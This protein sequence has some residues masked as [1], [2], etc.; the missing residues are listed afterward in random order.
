MGSLKVGMISHKPLQN[1][2][3]LSL[4][5][6]SGSSSLHA[7]WYLH[8]K[9]GTHRQEEKWIMRVVLYIIIFIPCVLSSHP[10]LERGGLC[11]WGDFPCLS[12]PLTPPLSATPQREAHSQYMMIGGPCHSWRAQPYFQPMY[13]HTTRVA[14]KFW[15]LNICHVTSHMISLAFIWL[16][17][18]LIM[19]WSCTYLLG[20]SLP[21]SLKG[22]SVGVNRSGLQQLLVLGKLCQ[23]LQGLLN[24]FLVRLN[25]IHQTLTEHLGRDWNH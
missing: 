18:W 15:M 10:F 6:Q 20:E 25:A 5:F 3:N 12:P 17:I 21:P 13:M 7:L 16:S 8:R 2:G 14:K 24:V 1:P 22:D 9:P 4:W 19:W 23:C 11:S